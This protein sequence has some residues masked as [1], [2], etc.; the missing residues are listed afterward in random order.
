[1]NKI[2]V[3]I[4]DSLLFVLNKIISDKSDQLT[5]DIH[6]KS[7]LFKNFI[8][9]KVLH[10]LCIHSGKEVVFET[11]SKE[12]KEMILKL[13]KSDEHFTDFIENDLKLPEEDFDDI[14]IQKPETNR[15]EFKFPDFKFVDLR[16]LYFVPAVL[17][18][19]LV[20][21][22]FGFL[23]LQNNSN[24]KVNISVGSERFVKTFDLKLSSVLNTD[25]DKKI[26]RVGSYSNKFNNMFNTK[27]G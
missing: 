10:K 24:V 5:L 27:E 9:L 6:P 22:G 3:E 14:N 19:I 21:L 17:I 23:V 4:N 2:T 25:I 8:N 26:F 16:K 1:M 15:K 13:N 18:F 12:G 20:G 7:I 11:S